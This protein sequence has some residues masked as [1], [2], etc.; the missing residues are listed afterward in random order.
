MCARR[1]IRSPGRKHGD[2][3]LAPT[4]IVLHGLVIAIDVDMCHH[5]YDIRTTY[6]TAF[7]HSYTYLRPPVFAQYSVPILVLW[8]VRNSLR[9]LAPDYQCQFL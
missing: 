6:T 9:T 1:N 5:Y 4:R 7:I 8:N 2:M 3:F